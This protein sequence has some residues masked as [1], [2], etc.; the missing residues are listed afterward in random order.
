M[1]A[2]IITAVG[3]GSG[4]GEGATGLD[5]SRFEDYILRHSRW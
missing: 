5:K 1:P 2:F 3:M 4:D